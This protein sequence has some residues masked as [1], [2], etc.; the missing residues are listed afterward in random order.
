MAYA[1]TTY[2][3]IAA[4][5]AAAVSAYGAVQSGQVQKKTAEFNA[6]RSREAA[7]SAQEAAASDAYKQM[8]IDEA[9][10]ASNRVYFA[11]SGVRIDDGTPVTSLS[12][13]AGKRAIDV[14]AIRMRGLQS[15]S[16]LLAQSGLYSMQ[17]TAAQKAGFI[18]AGSTL[19]SGA[20]Q[21]YSQYKLGKS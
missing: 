6:A 1:T 20:G 17:G 19:L 9:E 21:S 4:L 18:Q 15:A 2:I 3:A 5:A 16:N 11:T 7:T 14:A 10:M 13:Q 8:L 12:A